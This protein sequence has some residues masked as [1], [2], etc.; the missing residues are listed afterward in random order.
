MTLTSSNLCNY[1]ACGLLT[2]LPMAAQAQVVADVLPPQHPWEAFQK[3]DADGD[4]WIS[5][6]E[7]VTHRVIVANFDEVDRDRDGRLS[8]EEF[9][10]IPLNRSDQPGTL[11]NPDQG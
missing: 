4:G 6:T 11:R 3:V 9:Q 1:V 2:I 5:R 10:A 8:L 7:A